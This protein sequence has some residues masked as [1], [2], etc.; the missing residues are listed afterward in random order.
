MLSPAHIT[1]LN[2][3][4]HYGIRF[5]AGLILKLRPGEMGSE[6]SGVGGSVPR[7]GCSGFCPCIG[8]GISAGG[9]EVV[10]G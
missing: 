9:V 6:E 2:Q 7:I 10:D 1:S 5:I 3:G 8:A 4:V